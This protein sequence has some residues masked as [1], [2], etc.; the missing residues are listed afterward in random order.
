MNVL[1]FSAA[2]SALIVFAATAA[3]ADYPPTRWGMTLA[4]VR[5]VMPGGQV[6]PGAGKSQLY[7]T[8]GDLLG[9]SHAR[10][11]LEFNDG[12]LEM[13]FADLPGLQRNAVQHTLD[14]RLGP[15]F[16]PDL[17]FTGDDVAQLAN[18]GALD[19]ATVV[20]Q[21]RHAFFR[22]TRK[23]ADP[24]AHPEMGG[25]GIAK[26]GMSEAQVE[27]LYP[28]GMAVRT[29]AG[30]ASY[31]T[32]RAVGRVEAMY[33]EFSFRDDHLEAVTLLA[34][35]PG[36]AIDLATGHY[37]RPS[38]KEA[39]DIFELLRLGLLEKYGK[40]V[41]TDKTASLSWATEADDFIVL[42]LTLNEDGRTANVGVVYSGPVY[43]SS[44]TKGL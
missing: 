25:Y 16:H 21:S 29:Q 39:Q 19:G 24:S 9:F 10:L 7:Q 20:L 15:P 40:P 4:E 5:G 30:E 38:K 33:V 42:Q 35:S 6:M 14:S 26:W 23:F 22:S 11:L 43:D 41:P 44:M 8:S 32:I 12:R 36:T 31:R 18:P 3:R 34:G 13:I 2:L 37:I 28:G 27:R 17:W 1:R